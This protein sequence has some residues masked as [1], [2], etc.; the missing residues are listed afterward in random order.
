MSWPAASTRKAGLFLLFSVRSFLFY[1]ME[2][3]MASG[4]C[5]CGQFKFEAE[6]DP[7][8]VAYCHC[9]SCRRHT[10]SPVS[11]FVNLNLTQLRFSGERS[12]YASS[13]GV[14]RSFCATCGTPLAYETAERP[15][16]IDLYINVF[17]HPEAFIPQKHVFY[18]EHIAWFDVQDDLPRE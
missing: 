15:G 6:G 12:I 9:A 1:F 7:R 17:D 4:H 5:L 18:A 8:W 16:E 2:T 11:C 14:R 10:A 3:K 13:P